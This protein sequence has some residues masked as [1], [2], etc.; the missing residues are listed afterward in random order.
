MKLYFRQRFFSWFDSYDIYDAATGAR[1]FSVEGKPAWGHRLHI[2]DAQGRHI[3]TVKERVLTFL[4]KFELYIG[5]RYV[6]KVRKELT[7]FR[8]AFA[9]DGSGRGNARK[10]DILCARE[11][12]KLTGGF[13]PAKTGG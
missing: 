6:G 2:L 11:S 3:A 12:G 9:P 10:T 8:P 13:F 1:A 7:L 4:P 5:E